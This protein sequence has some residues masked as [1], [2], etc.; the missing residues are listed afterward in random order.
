MKKLVYGTAL[1]L[2]LALTFLAGN[3]YSLR[4]CAKSG[5]SERRILYYV[6]PMNPTHTSDKPGIAPC[7]MKMEP[8]YA[9]VGPTG[10]SA[11][12]EP[13][14]L[15]PGTVK[16][17]P[18]KQQTIGVK[19]AA[20]EKAAVNH[21]I[22][23]AGRIAPDEKRVYRLIAAADGLIREVYENETGTLVKK[24]EPLASFY[25]SQLP[26]AQQAYFFAL[27]AQS[28][29]PQLSQQS[30]LPR[31][32]R[33]GLQQYIDALEGLGMG[34]QQIHEVAETKQY[35][36]KIFMVSPATGFIITRNVS[37]GQ[38]F[39]KGAEWY[40]I[41][42][43]SRVWVLADLFRN[44]SEYVKAGMKVQV[45][46][47]H[48][49]KEFHA[50]VSKVLPQFDPSSRTLKVRLEL[51]NPGYA[52]RPNM[53]VDVEF[54]IA[55][56]PTI[57]VPADAVLDSG[58]KKTV[59]V[60]TGNGFFE[61]RQVETGRRM[62][63]RVEI[64]KG[65]MEGERIVVSGNFL[66]DSESKM[67]M[68]A[69]GMQTGPG[70]M[71]T[72]QRAKDPVCGMEVN[73]ASAKAAGRVS[74]FRGTTFYFCMDECK[75]S[76]QKDPGR[77]AGKKDTKPAPA[78]TSQVSEKGKKPLLQTAP[79]H[80]PAAP[81]QPKEADMKPMGEQSDSHAGTHGPTAHEN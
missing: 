63:D 60:D 20:V 16:I 31:T 48:Q 14:S 59:F 72:A 19:T 1:I 38:R 64:T 57:N 5:D 75:T 80:N 56:S 65:L 34:Q 47:P 66:I 30:Q 11:G 50:T 23:T 61:P 45:T 54:P 2:L 21:V 79:V 26:A 8:V 77:Y 74:E 62:G 7:G 52:L 53:F 6:D 32:G 25:N 28:G 39:E 27:G 69:A 49:Q 10:A 35:A 18:E 58:L 51:D 78:V 73:A 29:G 46:L 9:D 81:D 41:A 43:L 12:N 68:A 55:I 67:R 4:G 22:R 70:N 13:S 3:W 40:V 71:Q 36:D 37:P 76:F 44:E 17:T 24:G 33:L 42:D 15:A